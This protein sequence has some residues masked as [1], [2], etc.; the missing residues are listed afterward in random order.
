M[1]LLALNEETAAS[2]A[3]CGQLIAVHD[4]MLVWKHIVNREPCTNSA[5]E[6]SCERCYLAWSVDADYRRRLAANWMACL[7]ACQ[8]KRHKCALKF[9]KRCLNIAR[10][11]QEQDILMWMATYALWQAYKISSHASRCAHW[12]S[13]AAERG[14]RAGIYKQ[15]A[16]AK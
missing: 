2:L 13:V 4:F 8:N 5:F 12:R 9:A 11:Q 10:S 14:L 6:I 16:S 1:V 15:G 3:T 7:A